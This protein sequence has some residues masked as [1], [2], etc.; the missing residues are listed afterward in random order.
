MYRDKFLN[1]KVVCADGF[2]MSVQANKGAYCEPRTN[3]A[4]SYSAV[5]IGSPSE[6]EELIMPWAEYQLT[7]TESV[8]GY[9]PV[10]RVTEVIVKHGG[11]VSGEVP[12]GVILVKALEPR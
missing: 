10:Q 7:P 11:A 5:E 9:V 3:N 2:T 12:S 4:E 1:K 6:I 8:Y